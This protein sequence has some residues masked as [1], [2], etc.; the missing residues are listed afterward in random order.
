MWIFNQIFVIIYCHLSY[1]EMMNP[2]VSTKEELVQK[3]KSNAG[4]IR[5][6][7]ARSLGLFGSFQRNQ[8]NE[9]SDVDLLVEFSTGCKT[10]DNFIHLAF[11]LEDLLG[12][13]V[14]LI[15]PE[16]LSPY[17]RPHIEKNVEYVSF[18]N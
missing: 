6:Y 2:S 17:L 13:N 16:S 9:A 8:Q 3:L 18:A 4:T 5:M 1:E 15:T 14:E 12:R 11:F 7:G 10:Y